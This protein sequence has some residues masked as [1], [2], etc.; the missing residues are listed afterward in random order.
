VIGEILDELELTNQMTKYGENGR[1]KHIKLR[2]AEPVY[3]IVKDFL[4]L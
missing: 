3:G 4:H 2:D 1:I